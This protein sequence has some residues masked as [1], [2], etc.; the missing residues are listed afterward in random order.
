M[1]RSGTEL[2]GMYPI[3]A[4]PFHNDE[5]IDYG[6][7]KRLIDYLIGE[8]VDGMVIGA[9][10]SEGHLLS[11]SEKKSVAETVIRHTDGRVPVVVS[12]THFGAG[13]AA[14]NA[15]WA[16]SAGASAVLTLPP[17]FGRWKSNTTLIRDYLL[18]ISDAVDI[19]LMLQDH[20]LTDI[21]IPVPD[22]CRLIEDV[23]G[24]DYIKL[25]ADGSAVKLR[26]VLDSA[27]V[28]FRGIFT[29]LAGVRLFWE[30]E[31]GAVGCMPA[32]VPAK[33][34]AEIIHLFR[35]GR[36]DES[37][38]LFQ[39]WLPFLDFLLL[40]GR[41]D[42]VKEYLVRKGVISSPRLREPNITSW[43]DWCRGQFEYMLER[44]E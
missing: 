25:E 22:L 27:P 3:L 9:N 44:T 37:F 42:L 30:L 11:E 31:A 29:G 34:L 21:N 40:F 32:C 18:R 10:A 26:Q 28:G 35:E 33:P 4:T 16:Q 8:G 19:P 6:S 13:T 15:R 12:V 39:K 5:S 36:K 14:E 1:S 20:P 38:A 41:R 2:R 24:L 17:F 43:N 23:P 7:L